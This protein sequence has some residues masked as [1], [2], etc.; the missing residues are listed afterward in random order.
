MC[1]VYVASIRRGALTR[2]KVQRY[3]RVEI[4]TGE[5][6]ITRPFFRLAVWLLILAPTLLR[7]VHAQDNAVYAVTYVEI[8]ANAVAGG[9]TLLK[10]YRDTS[11]KQPGNARSDLLQEIVRP[12]RFA[13]V[14]TW[15][16]QA[17]LDA[18][19][20]A[21][22][23]LQIRDG[24]KSLEDAPYDERVAHLLYAASAKNSDRPAAMTSCRRHSARQ[25]RLHGSAQ[26][27]E[28]RYRQ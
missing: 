19:A 5:A 13:I 10:R 8:N 26:S 24:L 15:N 6:K 2:R 11:L 1:R 3:H 4:I 18:H 22:S 21:P 17:A 16:S 20:N 25:G 9:T 23:T 12:N 14:E 28:R 27:H 7:P